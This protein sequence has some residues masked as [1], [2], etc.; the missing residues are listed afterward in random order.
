MNDVFNNAPHPHSP[1][2]GDLPPSFSRFQLWL[3]WCELSRRDWPIN[4][5]GHQEPHQ[6][7]TCYPDQPQIRK[8][9][10]MRG[11][12]NWPK[13][14][15]GVAPNVL[16][17]WNSP[18]A[19]LEHHHHLCPDRHGQCLQIPIYISGQ[20]AKARVLLLWCQGMIYRKLLQ[21][22]VS[23]SWIFYTWLF[24][25]GCCPAVLPLWKRSRP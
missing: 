9:Y 2:N 19:A 17:S 10:E 25:V 6:H 8:W 4:Q 12:L 20:K 1:P 22:I 13:K 18:N 11:R 24:H 7:W 15:Q 16:T 3:A 21:S 5:K 14:T 23:T